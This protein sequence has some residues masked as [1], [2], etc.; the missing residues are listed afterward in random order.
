LCE[1]RATQRCDSSPRSRIAF[2]SVVL[3]PH[4]GLQPRH[5]DRYVVLGWSHALGV[6]WGAIRCCFVRRARD[7]EVCS[8]HTCLT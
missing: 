5:P 8:P 7:H 4:F 2:M 1:P 3:S 6:A